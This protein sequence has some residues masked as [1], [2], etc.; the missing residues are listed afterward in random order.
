MPAVRIG[1]PTF[2]RETVVSVLVGGVVGA[3]VLGLFLLT[4]RGGWAEPFGT[5]VASLGIFYVV[6]LLFRLCMHVLH[7][8]AHRGFPPEQEWPRE[9]MLKYSRPA[10]WL[11][12]G[13]FAAGMVLVLLG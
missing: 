9:A 4:D 8:L 1:R 10:L 7:D 11:G 5:T 13:G 3:L 12:A 2:L 6:G